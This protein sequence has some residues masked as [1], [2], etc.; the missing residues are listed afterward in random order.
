MT[1]GGNLGIGTSAPTARLH[2]KG[3]VKV[4]GVIHTTGAAGDIPMFVP[5]H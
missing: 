1:S 3:D 5:T 2:V 4:E